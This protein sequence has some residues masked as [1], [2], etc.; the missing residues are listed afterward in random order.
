MRFT[1][2]RMFVI[3]LIAA[4]VFVMLRVPMQMLFAGKKISRMW[5][6]IPISWLCYGIFG[7][8]YNII[9]AYDSTND[10]QRICGSIMIGY[11]GYTILVIVVWELIRYLLKITKHKNPELPAGLG[12]GKF[13]KGGLNDPPKTPRPAKPIGQGES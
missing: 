12:Q 3:T 9:G 10:V 7:K 1:I 6:T 5:L 2:S 4:L 8:V 11:L 13:V